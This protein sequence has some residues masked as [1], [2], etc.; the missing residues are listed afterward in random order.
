MYLNNELEPEIRV[1]TSGMWI[2][3]VEIMK[4]ILYKV[5]ELFFPLFLVYTQKYKS[6]DFFTQ[7]NKWAT[8]FGSGFKLQYSSLVSKYL[9]MLF[10]IKTNNLYEYYLLHSEYSI[11]HKFDLY[12]KYSIGKRFNQS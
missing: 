12:P 7:K 10:V 4:I 6:A 8:A 1:L 3:S 5:I 9:S 2:V 11:N